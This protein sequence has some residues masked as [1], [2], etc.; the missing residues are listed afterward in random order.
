MYLPRGYQMQTGREY[1]RVYEID[2][3]MSLT[4]E[5]K[6]HFVTVMAVRSGG[7]WWSDIDIPDGYPLGKVG[8]V[9]VDNE[10]WQFCLCC[11]HLV[12]SHGRWSPT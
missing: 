1:G 6:Q 2:M 11:R 7:T 12:N 10:L 3:A 9:L 5:K 4:F 8:F